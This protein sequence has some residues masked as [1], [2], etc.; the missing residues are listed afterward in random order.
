MGSVRGP[1]REERMGEPR[2]RERGSGSAGEAALQT[3]KEA[4]ITGRGAEMFRILR[5]L[6]GLLTILSK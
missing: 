1:H 5:R 2:G 3:E 4:R 6:L